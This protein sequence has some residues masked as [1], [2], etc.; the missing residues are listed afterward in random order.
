MCYRYHT[1]IFYHV[2]AVYSLDF[3]VI[4]IIL[5]PATQQEYW[6]YCLQPLDGAKV[7]TWLTN[8][9][10]SIP[11]NTEAAILDLTSSF[12]L[13]VWVLLVK[14]HVAFCSDI[15]NW[16]EPIWNR[17]GG[18]LGVHSHTHQYHF[19]LIPL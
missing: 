2:P 6:P 15:V 19:V 4:N 5:V 1:V 16:I 9:A 7:Q 14:T 8:G 17:R 11:V 13:A 12:D 10:L 18:G 3:A